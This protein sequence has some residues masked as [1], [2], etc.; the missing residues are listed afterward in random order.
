MAGVQ[1]LDPE[2][3]IK[4]LKEGGSAY[5][6]LKECSE[7]IAFA[8]K[9]NHVC[10]RNLGWYN[11]LALGLIG[12]NF[13]SQFFF[14]H[15]DPF[16]L[17]SLHRKAFS[18]QNIVLEQCFARTSTYDEPKKTD[19]HSQNVYAS[20]GHTFQRRFCPLVWMGTPPNVPDRD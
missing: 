2:L 18:S 16:L 20:K 5:H 6:L 13:E 7:K 8:Q 19:P 15:T 10:I 14:R 4:I 11:F 3:M 12:E 1:I 17:W 9:V